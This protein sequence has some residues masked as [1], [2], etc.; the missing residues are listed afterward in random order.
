M[1][2]WMFAEVLAM[3]SQAVPSVH[4]VMNLGKLVQR[5]E[6]TAM[7]LYHSVSW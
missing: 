6:I 1:K 3:V 2:L 4:D 5:T 7:N